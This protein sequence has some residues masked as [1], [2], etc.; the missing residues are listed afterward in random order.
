MIDQLFGVKLHTA[1]KSEETGEEFKVGA[2]THLQ[3]LSCVRP[4]LGCCTTVPC[5]GAGIYVAAN[6]AAMNSRR[7]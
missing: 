3:V 2:D 4:T 6:A 5:V 1:L 7:R